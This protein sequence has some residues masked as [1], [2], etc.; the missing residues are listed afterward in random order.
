MTEGGNF[1][2]ILIVE[3]DPVSRNLLQKTLR[4]FGYEAVAVEN[5]RQALQKLKGNFIPVVISDWMMPEMDGIE[6][7]REIRKA[8]LPGY[9][10]FILVTARDKKE[11]LISGLEAGAD[12]YL[13]KPFDRAELRARLIVAER[14]IKLEQSLKKANEEIRILSIT[15]PLTH[16]YNRG[17][18]MER[19][20]QEVARAK[21]YNHPLALIMSDLDFFKEIN[22]NYGHQT[23][24]QVLKQ[25][26]EAIKGKIRQG[27]DWIA[28][29][30]GEE[31]IIV[32]PETDLK[33]GAI[34]AER[35]RNLVAENVF[36]LNQIQL[37]ITAS[38]GVTSWDPRKDPDNKDIETIIRE[39]DDC[40]YQA[41]KEGR[42]RV[43]T[44]D[45]LRKGK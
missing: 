37:K 45:E 5:G 1:L 33:G 11:D 4:K 13:T 19:L 40:L 3:D 2:T 43:K 31:F 15:D 30:G 35:L 16:S 41:K 29:Y 44:I 26:V 9:V 38:F 20:P 10:Y 17:F 7:C 36:T 25:F 12:D 34:L 14:I 24:D 22:D 21:R 28:R 8:N 42:N 18:L 32:V 27:I 23:G 39:A 6:L